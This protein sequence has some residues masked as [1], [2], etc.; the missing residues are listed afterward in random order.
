MQ[1]KSSNNQA[2]Q[3]ILV[4][5]V[6]LGIILLLSGGLVGYSATQVK[7]ERTSVADT[8]AL[9]LAEAGIDKAVTQLNSSASYT[10][11]T[12]TA[13]GTGSF[14]VA[15]STI[16]SSNRAITSTGRST[17]RGIVTTKTVKATVGIN[18]A[19]VS[20]RYGVQTGTGGFI[21]SGGSTLNGN[22]YSN[23]NISATT[24]VHITGSAIAANLP[25][26]NA[27]QSNS[28]PVPISSCTSSTCISFGN[29]AGTEDFAQSFQI[30]VATPMNNMQFYLKKVGSPANRTV[31]IYT[32]NAGIPGTSLMSA[33]LSAAS[34][35]TSF[36]WVSV[37][38]PTTPVLDPSETYW[39]VLDGATSAANYYII[40]AN[41]AY[42][43]GVGKIG[44]F[45][46]TLGN[47]TPAGLDGYFIVNLGGGTSMIGGNSYTTGAYVGT[48]TSDETW[49]HTVTGVTASGTIYCQTATFTNKSCNT[50]RADPTPQSM[51]LSDNNIDDWKTEAAAGG[52]YAGNYTVGFAGATF[53]PK[54]I[55]GDLTVSGGGTLIVSGTLWIDGNINL[56]GG[57]KV[58]LAASYG[59]NSGV[60]VNDGYVSLTGG[61]NF[62][63]SGTAGS[64]PFLI[65]TSACPAAPGCAGND[66]IYLSGGAGTVALVAQNGN[67]HINGGSSLKAVTGKQITMDGGATLI[68]DAGLISENFSSGPGGSWQFIPGSYTI[69][70]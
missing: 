57:G 29:A 4:A 70:D 43:D 12:N 68:Y 66:A 33:T 38:L 8:Q 31:T 69:V 55:T 37:T 25:A 54:H 61:T 56:S 46:T 36:G 15:V 11:E 35:T 50:T 47:T 7:N 1:N 34:V 24:G 3:V 60:I 49:A 67:V 45:N 44:K 6:F 64:Y 2:G 30:S 51:P 10:G 48:T 9:Q 42:A 39:F 53:G 28:T 40:G 41:S 22:L 52:V 65:T 59:A 32:D 13:L 27:D 20:F 23:G 5:I 14:T 19:I 26:V 16:D 18:S 62:A 21:M 58:Q 63:G 17:F